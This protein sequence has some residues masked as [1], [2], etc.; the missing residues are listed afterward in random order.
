MAG[1]AQTGVLEH[2]GA[3][4]IALVMLALTWGTQPGPILAAVEAVFLHRR[5][6]G[7]GA[8]RGGGRGPGRRAVRV[9][10]ARRRGDGDRAGPDHRADGVRRKRR[11]DAGPRH[12]VCGVDDHHEWDCRVVA[13][14]GFA[15]VWRDTVQPPGQRRRAGH[16]HHAGDAEPG[17]AHVHHQPQWPGVLTGSARVRRRRVAAALPDVRLHPNRA[18]PRLL[19]AGHAE[20]STRAIRG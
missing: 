4:L 13:A 17:A 3:S 8:S 12:R 18:A 20:G 19:S 6:V 16:P 15:S 7:L 2:R 11:D 5:R 9:A 14:A 10:G 1:D